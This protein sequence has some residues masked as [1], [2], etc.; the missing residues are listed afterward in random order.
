MD[1]EAIGRAIDTLCREAAELGKIAGDSAAS[2]YDVDEGNARQVLAGLQD[3][4][5]V[6]MDT[7]PS[8]NL[9]GEWSD[10]PTPQ[11]LAEE[12]GCGESPD[13]VIDAIC[14]AWEDAAVLAIERNIE[15]RCINYA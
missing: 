10:D 11:S 7:L 3:I 4:D 13:Y 9:S 15:S 6:V 2:W 14:E 8:V 1:P 5:P 12:L